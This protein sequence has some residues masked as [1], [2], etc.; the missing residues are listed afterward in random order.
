MR[1]MVS[2]KQIDFVKNIQNGGTIY[3]FNEHTIASGE[4]RDLVLKAGD[5]VTITKLS[6]WNGSLHI[7]SEVDY[8]CVILGFGI[9]TS[10]TAS[11]VWGGFSS[12]D[13]SY[14]SGLPYPAEMMFN[15]DFVEGS[16]IIADLIISATATGDIIID[17]PVEL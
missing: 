13:M 3:K 7:F 9:L 6:Q 14:C 5:R 4:T 17:I 16:G 2:Q 12:V 8:S 1:K 11:Q 15:K 10:K